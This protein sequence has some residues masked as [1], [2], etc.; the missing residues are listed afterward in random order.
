M[1]PTYYCSIHPPPPL[2]PLQVF[3]PGVLACSGSLE[4]GEWVG[5][6]VAIERRV[7]GGGEERWKGGCTR[8]AVLGSEH[9]ETGEGGLGGDEC[10]HHLR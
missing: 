7:E 3:I 10:G 8:G 6:S 1:Q 9:A 5:V 4:A 2:L